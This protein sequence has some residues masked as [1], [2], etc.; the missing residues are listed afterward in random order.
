MSMTI[1]VF[2]EKEAQTVPYNQR[3]T[4]EL[5]ILGT[6]VQSSLDVLKDPVFQ[7]EAKAVHPFAFVVQIDALLRANIPAQHHAELA[8]K[9]SRKIDLICG[10]GNRS[11]D[12]D[13]RFWF[14]AQMVKRFIGV[15][16][17][18]SRGDI[19]GGFVQALYDA[20]ET[21]FTP[22]AEITPDHITLLSQTPE[23]AA[24][25]SVFTH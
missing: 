5:M 4:L 11:W 10:S 14:T 19:S 25:A 15:G 3:R 17:R 12:H 24:R 18:P 8:N 21:A 1:N 13:F 16:W 22:H 7:T 2:F 6:L 9:T 23:R 20:S